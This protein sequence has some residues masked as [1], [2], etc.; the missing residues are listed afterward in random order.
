[1]VLQLRSAKGFAGNPGVVGGIGL[2][3]WKEEGP[4]E[5]INK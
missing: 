4:K 2:E 5:V 1:M 3:C